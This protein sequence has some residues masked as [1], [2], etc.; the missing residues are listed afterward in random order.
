M[1]TGLSPARNGAMHNHQLPHRE[2]KKWPAYFQ[3]MGY[4]VAAIGKVA[5]Y[6]QVREYG[7]DHFSHFRYHEDDCIDAALKWLEGRDSS[8]PLCLLVGTNWPHV[9]W[10]QRTAYDPASMKLPPTHVDTPERGW[11]EPAMLRQSPTRTATWG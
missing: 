1:L 10:P 5:H 7:F 2:V 4:E 8:R 11:R 9:P 3:E 6:A